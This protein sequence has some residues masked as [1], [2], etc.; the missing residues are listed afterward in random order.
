MITIVHLVSLALQ[1]A[2]VVQIGAGN[3]AS[4]VQAVVQSVA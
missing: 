1:S 3:L 2:H 4:V